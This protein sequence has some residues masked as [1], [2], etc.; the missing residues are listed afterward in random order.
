MSAGSPV[1]G[2]DVRLS[3]GTMEK[4]TLGQSRAAVVTMIACGI[5]WLWPSA[6]ERHISHMEVA[7]GGCKLLP[8]MGLGRE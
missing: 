6:L 2:V 7:F 8:V 1:R 4:R 5:A 3:P